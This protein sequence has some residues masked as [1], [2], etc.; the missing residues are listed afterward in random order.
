M[1]NLVNR[2]RTALSNRINSVS[3]LPF[4]V[5]K[6]GGRTIFDLSTEAAFRA[7]YTAARF[8]LPASIWRSGSRVLQGIGDRIDPADSQAVVPVL[9]H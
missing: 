3:F 5:G 8:A 2:R 7:R 9:L 6:D 4:L 1:G